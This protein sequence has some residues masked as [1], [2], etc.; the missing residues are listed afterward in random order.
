MQRALR[1]DSVSIIGWF[2]SI[3]SCSSFILIR[4]MKT[5]LVQESSTTVL[6]ASKRRRSSKA[7]D[8]TYLRAICEQNN[9][10]QWNQNIMLSLCGLEVYGQSY[11]SVSIDVSHDIS[12]CKHL[13]LP[14]KLERRIGSI[15]KA[16]GFFCRSQVTGRRSQVTGCRSQ[17]TV[18]SP[19]R[20]MP[21]RHKTE[22]RPK[23]YYNSFFAARRIC[24]ETRINS[25]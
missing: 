14:T 2:A 7:D 12:R 10:Q 18:H 6:Q 20:H 5:V 16:A 25:L 9:L 3:S 22:V 11:F 23:C 24:V 17:V 1:L 21:K 15:F 4:R 19:K 8:V 13:F